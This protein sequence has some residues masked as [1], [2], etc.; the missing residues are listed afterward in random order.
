ML[1]TAWLSTGN[2]SHETHVSTAIQSQEAKVWGRKKRRSWVLLRPSV[3]YSKIKCLLLKTTTI[4]TLFKARS[5]NILW[6]LVSVIQSS[7]TVVNSF[8]F[9]SFMINY[10]KTH[11]CQRVNQVFTKR[12]TNLTLLLQICFC[13]ETI[14]NSSNH[15]VK[16]KPNQV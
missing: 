11:I 7:Y 6:H 4:L 12:G 8:V 9:A 10:W 15:T 13:K 1:S 14:R 16:C 2:I 3:F 5:L